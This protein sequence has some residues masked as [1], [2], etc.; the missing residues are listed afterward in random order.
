MGWLTD[1]SQKGPEMPITIKPG[2]SDAV[3]EVYIEE[4]PDGG[5]F[6]KPQGDHYIFI[7]ISNLSVR[8]FG[9]NED[10]HF[11]VSCNG[12]LTAIRRGQK[13]VKCTIHEMYMNM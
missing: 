6:R 5:C 1:C 8:F 12:S 4:I 11:G 9:L 10:F 2:D 3:E 13:V 7:K